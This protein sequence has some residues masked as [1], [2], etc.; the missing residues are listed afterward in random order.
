MGSLLLG[1]QHCLLKLAG[2][3]AA[4][5]DDAQAHTILAQLANL[6]AQGTEEQL[7]ERTDL[8]GRALPVFAGEGKQGQH[9]DPLLDADLNHCLY[10]I[11]TC[12]V[13]G[14]AGHQALARPTVV[15]IHDDGNVA[16]HDGQATSLL[17]VVH[18]KAG[19]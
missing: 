4:I 17:F 5:T 2:K 16:R 12:L 14:N 3:P 13:P 11:N 19:H 1:L 6:A 9:L 10:R 7:H 15:A 8:V 18:L